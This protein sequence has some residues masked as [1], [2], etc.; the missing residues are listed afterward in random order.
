[1]P[2]SIEDQVAI[3]NLLNRLNFTIDDRDADGWVACF[4]PDGT[5]ENPEGVHGGEAAHRK[6][7]ADQIGLPRCQ[8][9]MTNLLIEGDGDKAWA[10]ANGAVFEEKDGQYSLSNF[11]GQEHYFQKLDGQ[12]LISRTIRH[13]PKKTQG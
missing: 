10:R 6:L 5:F 8:H 3:T 9:T 2:L 11:S 7:V 12:W 1:M 4:T 13:R